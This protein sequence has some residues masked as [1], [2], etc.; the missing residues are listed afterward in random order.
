[1]TM[2]QPLGMVI[3][4]VGVLMVANATRAGGVGEAVGGFVV[5][6]LFGMVGG[7]LVVC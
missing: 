7:F 5:G 6:G 3:A 1:M 4:G 2:L